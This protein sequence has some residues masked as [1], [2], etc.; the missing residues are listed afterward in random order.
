MFIEERHDRIEYVR[1]EV[2]ELAIPDEVRLHC[3]EG[4]YQSLFA[5]ALIELQNAGDQLAPIF[6]FID[7]SVTPTPP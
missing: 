6:A 5:A 1:G 7:L 3:L 4:Q 2:A